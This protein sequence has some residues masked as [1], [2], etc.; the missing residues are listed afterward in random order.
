[1]LEGFKFLFQNDYSYVDIFRDFLKKLIV[2]QKK[3][4]KYMKLNQKLSSKTVNNIFIYFYVFLQI[5]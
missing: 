3:K 2:P 4:K 1:M 5:L